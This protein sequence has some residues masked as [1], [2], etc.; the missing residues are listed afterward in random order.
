MEHQKEWICNRGQYRWTIRTKSIPA[1]IDLV[2]CS[3]RYTMV[4]EGGTILMVK[5]SELL[6]DFGASRA[7]RC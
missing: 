2:K 7:R 1:S 4:P 6:K 5:P 3:I